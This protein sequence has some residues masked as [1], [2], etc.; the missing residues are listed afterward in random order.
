M[1]DPGQ[2]ITLQLQAWAK[3]DATALD[4]VTPALYQELRRLA[5]RYLSGERRGH[6]LQPTALIGEAFLRLI[7]EETRDW[8]SRRHF[9]AIAAR[10]M[11]QILVEHARARRR[12]KRSSGQRTVTFDDGLFV[13]ERSADLIALDDALQDLER[14]DPRKA[15]V[16]E[17]TYFGGMTQA[18]IA[19][20]LGV[21][22]NTVARDRRLGEAWLRKQIR[23]AS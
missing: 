12:Q 14:A 18:E 4:K 2:D 3:G 15:Q 8:Q 5:A 22:E 7:G 10:C 23:E 6:T 16:V 13:K 21:H 1:A 9:V 17:L 11:R 19:A 20:W